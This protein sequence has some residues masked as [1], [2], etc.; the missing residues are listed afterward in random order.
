MTLKYLFYVIL[1][2]IPHLFAQSGGKFVKPQIH[3]PDSF[4]GSGELIRPQ[5]Q[6]PNSLMGNLSGYVIIEYKI[7]RNGKII[8]YYLAVIAIYKGKN[9]YSSIDIYNKRFP[10][11]N[12]KLGLKLKRKLKNWI[13]EYGKRT[14]FEKGK[15]SDLYKLREDQF[16]LDGIKIDFG[17]K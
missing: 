13:L 12:K 7:D 2:I 8:S 11:M 15:N 14:K 10:Q 6:F 5:I 16:V 4:Q 1:F 9:N 3:L 17:K